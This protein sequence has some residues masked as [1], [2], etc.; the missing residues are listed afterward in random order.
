M[1]ED[2]F[3][4]YTRIAVYALIQLIIIIAAI[5]F[6]IKHTNLAT[7]LILIGAVFSGLMQIVTPIIY[8]YYLGDNDIFFQLNF[9]ISLI[10][11]VFYALFGI[12]LLLL[13]LGYKKPQ[14]N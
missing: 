8:Q 6:V 2:N 10:S 11:S 3:H 1:I 9:I 7:I 14:I 4:Q 5:L 13:A 12:G